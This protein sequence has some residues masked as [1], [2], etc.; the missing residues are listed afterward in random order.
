MLLL[1]I[2][3]HISNDSRWQLYNYHRS[4]FCRPINIGG[5]GGGCGVVVVTKSSSDG[6]GGRNLIHQL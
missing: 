3:L 6:G 5:V 1:V 4:R 2:T